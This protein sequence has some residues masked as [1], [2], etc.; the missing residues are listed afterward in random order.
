MKKYIIIA[1][2]L[3]TLGL[4]SCEKMLNYP[5]TG[6][7]LAEDAL[8]TPEDAQKL[9]NSCYDVMANVFDGSYQNLAELMS[10][11]LATPNGL[12]F[13]AVYNKE[14]NFFTPTTNGVYADLYYAIYRCNSL[15][16]NFD[17]IDGLSDADRSR[18]EAE[19]RFI[20][21]FCH[22]HVAKIWAQPYGYTSDNSHLGIVIRDKASNEPLPRNTVAEVYNF[23][24]SEME[25]AAS[26]LPSSNGNYATASAAKAALAMIY[27][28]MRDYSKAIQYSDEVINANNF[29]Q[30]SIDR[31]PTVSDYSIRLNLN[32]SSNWNGATLSIHGNGGLV[33]TFNNN[34]NDTVSSEVSVPL[35]SGVTYQLICDVP[36]GKASNI[37]FDVMNPGGEVVYS[38]NGSLINANKVLATFTAE[39]G[40]IPALTASNNKESIFKIV[41]F[42]NDVR[43]D[44]FIGNYNASGVLPPNLTLW[45]DASFASS[46]EVEVPF[47]QLINQN[48]ADKRKD[49]W[50]ATSGSQI[51][52]TKFQSKVAFNI[53][54]MYQTEMMLIRAE[55]IAYAQTGR[56]SEAIADINAIRSRAYSQDNSLSSNA[57]AE[58]VKEAA[59]KEYRLETI[60]EGK[61]LDQF[62]RI[63]IESNTTLK[64]RTSPWNCPGMALQFPN[65]EFTSALFVGNPEGGCN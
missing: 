65:N 20:R 59:R 46:N 33:T 4:V 36:G 29:E 48:S 5:P 30:Y 64:I 34:S 22:W 1:A 12:D 43:T 35:I 15:L 32:A 19:A 10:N 53:P 42:S 7:I 24:V 54:L 17:L 18:M 14:T 39:T 40:G 9:L 25:V 8:K 21:A 49:A 16:E 50:M 31:F 47:V 28:Q 63:A 23:I 2:S 61:W 55:A 52:L 38:F 6:A 60:G 56:L 57:T 44:D 41:S 51:T 37:S 58:Q 45:S 62:R 11:N 26:T 3:I 27:F 13:K